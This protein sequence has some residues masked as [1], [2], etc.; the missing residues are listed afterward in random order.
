MGKSSINGPFSMAMLNNQRVDSVDDHISLNHLIESNPK[1]SCLNDSLSK[2]SGPITGN[3]CYIAM[4]N[5]PVE[6]ELSFLIKKMLDLSRVFGERLPE[7]IL[8]N[9]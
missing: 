2:L 4:E 5:G 6:S 9:M 8:A 3:D 7:G 1:S